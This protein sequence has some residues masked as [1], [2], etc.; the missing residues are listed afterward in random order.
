MRKLV[1]GVAVA[2]IMVVGV[3]SA[4]EVFQPYVKASRLAERLDDLFLFAVAVSILAGGRAIWGKPPMGYWLVV[5]AAALAAPFVMFAHEFRQFNMLSLLF[6]AEFGT[7]GASLAG[8]WRS[9]FVALSTCVY[10]LL[11]VLWFQNLVQPRRWFLISMTV[12]IVAINPLTQFFVDY[13]ASPEAEDVLTPRLATPQISETAP[14]PDIVLIYLEGLEQGF[15]A[16]MFGTTY[17]EIEALRPQGTWFSNVDE[18]SGTE[19]SIAGLAA[20]TCGLPLVPNGLKFRNNFESQSDFFGAHTCLSDILGELGYQLSFLKGTDKEFA[21]FNHF[22][23]S[24]GFDGVIDRQAQKARYSS[25]EYTQATAGWAIDDQMLM[26]TARAEYLAQTQNDAPIAMM[27]ETIGPHGGTSVMS[28]E[29][30]D[31]GQAFETRNPV[32]AAA[33]TL[34]AVAGFLT[35]LT[36]NRNGRPTAVLLL[37]DHLNHSGSVSELLDRETRRNTVLFLGYGFDSPIAAAGTEVDKL[38]TML[39]MY[40]TILAWLGL[41]PLDA[42]GGLGVSLFSDVPTLIEEF[43]REGTNSQLMPNPKLA[44]AIWGN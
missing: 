44:T 33:C 4:W 26:D 30:S 12:L 38:S 20:S 13:L 19:W 34:R 5:A 11:A 25:E 21:G 40:P 8:M 42:R 2:A 27:I 15:G 1:F 6:H 7:E 16:P 39:D 10:F 41:A 17:K 43:G 9:M 32:A 28:R 24:H 35:F 37:S 22:L 23:A 36:E 18:V 31:D 29:C 14:R 3:F